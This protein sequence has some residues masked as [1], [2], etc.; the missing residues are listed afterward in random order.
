VKSR[1][2]LLGGQG[3]G[4]PI[5]ESRGRARSLQKWIWWRVSGRWTGFS[6]QRD[7][8]QFFYNKIYCTHTHDFVNWDGVI[9]NVY[10]QRWSRRTSWRCL[11]LTDS[12]TCSS[13]SW[14]S[15]R[16]RCVTRHTTRV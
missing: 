10:V 12:S 16:R 15:S 8:A 13:V 6:D 5:T 4:S 14:L 2:T 1:R 7:L 9:E 3:D 11:T